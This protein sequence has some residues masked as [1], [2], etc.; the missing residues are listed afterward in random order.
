MLLAFRK[1]ICGNAIAAIAPAIAIRSNT[2]AFMLVWLRAIA[3]ISSQVASFESCSICFVDDGESKRKASASA[4][5]E[6]LC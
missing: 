4:S 6:K 1:C 5:T 2:F 3:F